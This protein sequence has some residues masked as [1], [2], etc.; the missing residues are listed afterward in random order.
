[1]PQKRIAPATSNM[2]HGTPRAFSLS[3]MNYDL[4]VLGLKKTDIS[5]TDELFVSPFDDH[6]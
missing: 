6:L 3:L 4:A 5:I 1:M 2:F